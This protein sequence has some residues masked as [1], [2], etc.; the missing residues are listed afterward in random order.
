[1]H[2]EKKLVVGP[3]P[4]VPVAAVVD[5]PS[6]PPPAH[7]QKHT[8]QE[9]SS[10]SSSS[11]A[12]GNL[13][14]MEKSDPFSVELLESNDVLE[15][16][17]ESAAKTISSLLQQQQ[18]KSLSEDEEDQLISLQCRLPILQAKLGILVAKVQSEALSFS[19]YLDMIKERLRRDQILAVYLRSLQTKVG[20]LVV[21]A[22]HLTSFFILM[23]RNLKYF[24][25]ES[26]QAA[27]QVFRRVKIMT[28]EVK[29]AESSS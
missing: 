11:V 12:Y 4:A 9:S 6:L 13:T 16:E 15:S 2:E 25:K 5:A 8:V 23:N 22:Q 28:E 29:S 10:S 18:Q 19:E 26:N 17:I 3:W 24:F 20:I 27:L 21:T 7:A 14:E 1:M